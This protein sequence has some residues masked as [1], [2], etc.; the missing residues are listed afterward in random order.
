M[1]SIEYYCSGKLQYRLYLGFYTT[2]LHHQS[3][4]NTL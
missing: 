1:I 4:E 3:L 2:Q